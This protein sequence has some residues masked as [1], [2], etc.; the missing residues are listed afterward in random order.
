MP[1]TSNVEPRTPFAA[2]LR[3]LV[4]R[5]SN[6]RSARPTSEGLRFI[7][8]SLA[9]GIAA[10]NTGNNLLYLLLAMMISLI[11]LSGILS[12]QCLRGVTVRR[13][14]PEHIFA[15]KPVTAT[16]TLINPKSYWAAFSLRVLDIVGGVT[17]DRGAHVFY[18]PP[19]GAAVQAYPLL[20]TRRG[21]YRVDGIKLLTRFPFGLFV[22]VRTVPAASDVVVYPEIREV[23]EALRRTLAAI[24]YDQDLPRRGQGT[25]LYHLR[26]YQPGDDSRSIHWKVSARQSMPI[27]REPEAEDRRRVILALSTVVPAGID[28]S[29]QA[30]RSPQHPFE[31]AVILV[32]SLASFFNEQGYAI[33]L[34]I[35]TYAI[36]HGLGRSQLYQILKALALCSPLPPSEAESAFRG[37]Q[38]LADLT[39]QGE[40]T[41]LVLPW[42]DSKAE[43]AAGPV[44][45]VLHAMELP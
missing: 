25:G 20:V 9:I 14:L 5:W 2:P 33:G 1:R 38:R 31:Q 6:R 24:G 13:R 32:A 19:K 15:N 35:G 36:P 28:Y 30:L 22:K 11:V 40:F 7:L 12:E 34:R 29:Q 17:V 8:L 39:A 42:A 27:V 3:T 4:R 23:P 18:L 44:S 45:H 10:I 37:L 21:R 16:F 26:T 43:A 41:L